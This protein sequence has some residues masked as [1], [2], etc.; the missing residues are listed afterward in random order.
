MMQC[1][2]NL[3]KTFSV[4]KSHVRETSLPIALDQIRFDISRI[5]VSFRCQVI[6]R[7]GQAEKSA[8]PWLQSMIMVGFCW[9]CRMNV[10]C[11]GHRCRCGGGG[12][13]GGGLVWRETM[14]MVQVVVQMVVIHSCGCWWKSSNVIVDVINGLQLHFSCLYKTSKARVHRYN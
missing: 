1:N 6:I 11:R 3:R 7:E 13:G 10:R 12:G 8:V 4:H 14:G 2:T 5:L 9:R